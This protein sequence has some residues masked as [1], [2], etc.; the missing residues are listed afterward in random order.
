M[1]R[2]E[3]TPPASIGPTDDDYRSADLVERLLD[4][5]VDQFRQLMTENEKRL[6]SVCSKTVRKILAG[7]TPF[8][9][10]EDLVDESLQ[11]TY[12]NI[13]EAIWSNEKQL[14]ENLK[15]RGWS[16]RIAHNAASNLAKK[17]RKHWK[18]RCRGEEQGQ[19]IEAVEEES[20]VV[21]RSALSRAAFNE[22]RKEGNAVLSSLEYERIRALS[23]SMIEEAKLPSPHKQIFISHVQEGRTRD[24][25]ARAFRLSPERV[26]DYIKYSRSK[27]RSM[28]R[29]EFYRSQMRVLALGTIGMS[30]ARSVKAAGWSG[31]IAKL[32]FV[33]TGLS[34]AKPATASL[35]V[36][37]IVAVAALLAILPTH[38]LPLTRANK[39]LRE[40]LTNRKIASAP[41]VN[42]V[43]LATVTPPRV[44]YQANDLA[45]TVSSISNPESVIPPNR[46]P[47][48]ASAPNLLSDGH[49]KNMTVLIDNRIRYNMKALFEDGSVE[50]AATSKYATGASAG[51][52]VGAEEIRSMA[53]R[54][55]LGTVI[56]RFSPERADRPEIF[57]L[58]PPYGKAGSEVIIPGR[59]FS[60]GGNV[61]CLGGIDFPA[62]VRRIAGTDCL[63]FTVPDGSIIPSGFLL[64][65]YVLNKKGVCS[66][67]I[68]SF[69]LL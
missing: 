13:W 28:R 16:G 19:E 7:I 65:L 31:Y 59:N 24:E 38:C 69:G 43:A 9:I 66:T 6:R 18:T 68:L 47:R 39:N 20:G 41:S 63:A 53:S 56:S 34:T 54:S 32:K 30:A 46:E 4:G 52:Y 50:D 55:E 11:I 8:K 51:N 42:I 48:R 64:N 26:S 67:T 22:W 45:P 36:A 14:R 37:A 15:F 35:G 17:E 61:V 5:D 60:Q 33:I 62:E 49:E 40:V 27:I 12:S 57:A 29:W 58:Q 21:S 44:K 3:R 23:M 2:A 10:I 25:I 1:R